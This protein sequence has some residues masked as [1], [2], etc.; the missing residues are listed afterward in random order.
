MTQEEEI[1]ALLRENKSLL[2][3]TY[4]S[5]EKTRK[6]I[7]WTGIFTIVAFVLPL[8][9]VMVYLPTLINTYT[10]SLGAGLSL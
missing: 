6:Y 1:L 9:A 4:R 2:E 7:L 8:I 5:A 10:E 3:A